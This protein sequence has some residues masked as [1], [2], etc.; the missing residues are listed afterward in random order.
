MTEADAA[1]SV[2]SEGLDRRADIVLQAAR[3]FDLHGY[4]NTSMQQI[5]DAV[6][7]AK[8]TLYHYFASKDAILFQIHDEFIDILL[9]KFRSRRTEAAGL[10]E[11]MVGAM[12]DI[13]S[14]MET[15][16]GHVRA[17]FEHHRELPVKQQHAIRSKRDEYEELLTS[18]LEWG[19]AV[20]EIRGQDARV[21]ALAVFGMC[22]WAYQWYDPAGPLRPQELA[23][24]FADLLFV[25]MERHD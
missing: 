22:N 11:E 5:A 10:R 24:R 9:D 18:L 2:P 13:L 21:T 16:R 14:L 17:F 4:A 1:P 6:S 7:V 12:G 19:Q 15:H 8:P 20:G 3:L 25:G 23:E